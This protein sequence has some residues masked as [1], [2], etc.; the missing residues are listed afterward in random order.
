MFKDILVPLVLGKIDEAAVRAACALAAAEEGHVIALVAVSLAM[1]IAAAWSYY[2][3][4]VYE[5]MDQAAKATTNELAHAIEQRLARETVAH[6]VRQSSSFWLTLAEVSALHARHADL[7]VLGIDR[8]LDDAQRRLFAGLLVGCGRPLLVVPASA[9]VRDSYER[10]VVAWKPSREASRAVHD[11]LPLLQRARSVEV[12]LVDHDVA[13]GPATGDMAMHLAAHLA[14]HGVPA[15]IVRR[16]G[17]HAR[18]G[19]VILEHARERGADLIVAGGYS[20]TR[21]L[22]QVFG[23]VT[24]TLLEGAAI[25]VLFSH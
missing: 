25:P 4:G 6:E 14:R 19:E 24:R 16:S 5:N 21:A 9:E 15:E 22:E 17:A 11:A 8:P 1:P 23:G 7:A 20:H 12:L 18:V 10:V 13:A 3:V 2:P